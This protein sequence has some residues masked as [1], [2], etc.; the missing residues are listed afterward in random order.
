MDQ[1]SIQIVKD[2]MKSKLPMQILEEALT[3]CKFGKFHIRLLAATICSAFASM[4]VVTTSSYILPVAECDLNMNLMHKGLL[5][6]IPFVGQIGASLFTGFLVDAFGRKL[7]L[8]GG[9]LGIFV[10][11]IIEGSS[12]TYWMLM[13]IKVIQGISLSLSFSAMATNISEF[14]PIAIRDRVLLVNSSFVSLAIVIAAAMSWMILPFKLDVVIWPG[15]FELHAW[16]FYLYMCSI[17]SFGAFIM[18]YNLP[19][20]PKYLL[21]HGRET[22]ALE[23]LKTIFSENTGNSGDAFP[24]HSFST[25]GTLKPT[26]EL[27][28]K[29]QLVNAL[30]E[31]KELFRPPL[32]FR[33]LFFSF[34][35]F[36][37][38][39]SFTSLRLWFPQLSTMI[40]NYDK[41]HGGSARFC[42]MITDYMDSLNVSQVNVSD[43]MEA[44]VCV[45]KLSGS[46]TYINGIILGFI[47]MV[48]VGIS[49]L[50]VDYLG[51]KILLFIILL[52]STV[53]STSLYW[54]NA[55][56]Q[57]AM[58]MSATCGLLQ[59]TVM[60][61]QNVFV[62]V[63]PTT[64]RALAMS[65]IIMFGRIGSLTGNIIFPLLLETG[66]MAPFVLTSGISLCVAILV[67]FLPNVNKEN[68]ETGDK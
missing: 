50:L 62:R 26:I 6:A 22:E 5:N 19:E 14:C 38:L 16:N 11:T 2:N 9:N 27:S 59:T 44:A 68:K 55:S 54:T 7:F 28:F 37:S 8:V 36:S 63:F 31:V 45:P 18:Y 66:C 25:S 13:F 47:S 39:I 4:F 15:Y 42:V 57:I 33:L 41:N 51:Q 20:S 46:Q 48:F 40:E 60:L 64:L 53:C 61:Q 32:V 56:L 10:C 17:W 21:S 3:F 29:K 43:V 58:L 24:I 23:V 52:M 30:F 12:Q 34:I 35:T 1:K 67:F 65:I 49:A